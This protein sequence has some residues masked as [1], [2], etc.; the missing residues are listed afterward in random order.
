MNEHGRGYTKFFLYEEEFSSHN[1]QRTERPRSKMPCCVHR[2]GE[3]STLPSTTDRVQQKLEERKS[4]RE[5]K[6]SGKRKSRNLME[7]RTESSSATQVP[8]LVLLPLKY[9][10]INK[11][12][13]SPL[14]AILQ[15]ARVRHQ[16]WMDKANE[17]SMNHDRRVAQRDYWCVKANATKM[18]H[19]NN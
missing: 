11:L 4:L 3:E 13:D 12:N 10:V 9:N 16:K 17:L 2:G 18:Y 8:L 1:G 7:G 5:S 15:R 6:H 14:H 19:I